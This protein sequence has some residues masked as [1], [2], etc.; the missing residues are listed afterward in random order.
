MVYPYVDCPVCR[1]VGFEPAPQV[2]RK[3]RRQVAVCPYVRPRTGMQCQWVGPFGEMAAHIHRIPDPPRR[4]T[5]SAPG[6]R[7]NRD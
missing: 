5:R 7:D 6:R 2:D 4:A 1:A 3:L